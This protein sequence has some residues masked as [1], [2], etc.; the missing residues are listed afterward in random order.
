MI[1][2]HSHILH[3]IDDGPSSIKET[4]ALLEHARKQG[5]KAIIATPHFNDRNE[6]IFN[7]YNELM[8]EFE[9]KKIEMVIALGFEMILNEANY[10]K[11]MDGCVLTLAD[12]RY[13]LIELKGRKWFDVYN[14]WLF[15][16]QMKGFLPI[17]AHV[18]R[19]EFLRENAMLISDLQN[20]GIWFQM[21]SDYVVKNFKE[22]K[23]WF[24]NDWIQVIASDM[25]DV[26]SRK[27]YM[28]EAYLKVKK[29]YGLNY[30]NRLFYHNPKCILSSRMR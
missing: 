21:N 30:A 11:L 10:H 13:V 14:E 3:G 22:A 25:H 1:D 28:L 8:L 18:E 15:N 12:G 7:K 16:L 5:V 9:Q 2:V 19:Y 29:S 17:I 6:T 4:I 24:E 26:A 27:S 20:N 23:K